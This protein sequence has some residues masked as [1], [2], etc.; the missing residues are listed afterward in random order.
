VSNVTVRRCQGSKKSPAGNQKRRH[1]GQNQPFALVLHFLS[2]DLGSCPAKRFGPMCPSSPRVP[3]GPAIGSMCRAPPSVRA[4]KPQE[5]VQLPYRT[6]GCVRGARM[7]TRTSSRTRSVPG[8][9]PRTENETG[10]PVG[11][12]GDWGEQAGALAVPEDPRRCRQSSN[13]RISCSMELTKSATVVTCGRVSSDSAGDTAPPGTGA[14][15]LETGRPSRAGRPYF[16]GSRSHR[17]RTPTK[18]V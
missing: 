18:R 14:R 3:G 16:F 11:G 15:W 6:Q 2:S 9:L 10:R 5:G 13:T 7:G 1:H 17:R 4:P 12:G 8:G